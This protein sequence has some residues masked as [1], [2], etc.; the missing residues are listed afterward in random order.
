[1]P[2]SPH[3]SRREFVVVTVGA[4]GTI[5]VAAVGLPAIPYLIAP[6]AKGQP[7][8]AWIPLGPLEN[9][10]VGEP[11]LITFTRTEVNGWERTSTSYG[12]YVFRKG[13]GE[14]EIECFDNTCTHLSCRVVWKADLKEYVCPCHDAHFSADGA[15]VSGPPPAPLNQYE[16]K[17]EEGTLYI[18]LKEA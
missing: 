2:Q 6:A 4:L 12:V 10:P 16:H 17:V 18:F 8:E 5:I 1:M 13:E 7:K 11:T 9:F 15:V 3:L 14:E